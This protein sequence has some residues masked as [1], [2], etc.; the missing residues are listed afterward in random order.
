M[1]KIALGKD[2]PAAGTI[3]NAAGWGKVDDGLFTSVSE[4]LNKVRI[5]VSD[6]TEASGYYGDSID[7][8]TKICIDASEQM[9]TC[10]VSTDSYSFKAT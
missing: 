4:T 5:S 1:K 10:N 8:S 9:G 3:V 7:W 6:D 2:E